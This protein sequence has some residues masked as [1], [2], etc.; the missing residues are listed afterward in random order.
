MLTREEIAERILQLPPDKRDLAASLALELY[1]PAPKTQKF[2]PYKFHPEKYLEKFLHWSPWSGQGKV[3]G[4]KEILDSYILAI[5][6][7]LEKRDFENGKISKNELVYWQPDLII[8]N[9]LRIEAGHTVGKTKL[10][11]GIVSH[12]LDCFVPSII[13]TFAPSF[14][15]I[16]KLLWKEIENDRLN[17]FDLPG[18]VLKNCQIHISPNHFAQGRAASNANNKGTERVQ[19]Q[20]NE[21]LLFVL[22]EAEGVADFVYDAV[23]SMISGGIA[24]VILLANPKTRT[25]KFHQI[26]KYSNVQSFRISCINHP[27]VLANRE[28]IPGAVRR[29][30]VRNMIEKHCEVV[31]EHQEEEHTFTLPFEINIKGKI[32][33]PETIFLPDTECMFRVL[34]IA[35]KNSADRNIIATGVYESAIVRPHQEGDKTTARI[36]VDV[37]RFGNDKGT[38]YVK[39]N[40][41]VWKERDFVKLDSNVYFQSLKSLAKDLREKGV[42]SL[43]LRVDGGGG[44]GSGLIDKAKIDHELTTSFRDFQVFEVHFNGLPYDSLKYSN[45]IT[46]LYGEAN[47]T[48]KGITLQNPP[49]ILMLDLCDRNYKWVNKEGRDVKQLESKDDFRKRNE[50]RSPDDGDGLVLAVAP[51]FLFKSTMIPLPTGIGKTSS[52]K[53]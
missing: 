20:H 23:D 44:F 16:K 50:N 34:G 40:N 3:I 47:E 28:I 4:Q 38:M 17:N 15:Q 53:A 29:D 45:A 51:D 26:K 39:W 42:T 48:L 21:Y 37:S 32:Y 2:E 36:G 14:D 31:D 9:I 5:R 7:Q 33:P 24:V 46:E 18:K 19:G 41:L 27:N 8:K 52:W 25:S 10:A 22:D 35:P 13:Y 6:Q 1:G 30:Y 43:H 12:F 49:E 11:S